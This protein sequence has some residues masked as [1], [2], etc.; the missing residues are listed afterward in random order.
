MSD[1][2]DFIIHKKKKIL[3][4]S[5]STLSLLYSSSI[6]ISIDFAKLIVVVNRIEISKPHPTNLCNHPTRCTGY[7]NCTTLA[8]N[9]IA[10]L[11]RFSKS[12]DFKGNQI[13]MV[14]YMLNGY[15]MTPSTTPLLGHPVGI[16]WFSLPS[17][18]L[19]IHR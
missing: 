2:S 12:T 8:K 11:S 16:E 14:D 9:E 18:S 7:A 6:S 5:L 13:F 4:P 17:T 19:R 15:S 1:T 3:L 10:I